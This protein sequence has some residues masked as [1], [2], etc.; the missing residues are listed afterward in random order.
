MKIS[1]RNHRIALI[2]SQTKSNKPS[3]QTGLL[4]TIVRK[5]IDSCRVISLTLTSN[6]ILVIIHR[7]EFKRSLKEHEFTQIKSQHPIRQPTKL[8]NNML[9]K[10]ETKRTMNSHCSKGSDPFEETGAKAQSTQQDSIIGQ[11][12]G[13]H[14][15]LP[16]IRLEQLAA[17][18]VSLHGQVP[19][20]AHLC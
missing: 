10:G 6:Y 19:K 3:L 8:S 2:R 4:L 5:T 16:Q 7:N 1:V 14:A 17:G 12:P 9:V 15:E 20:L 11:L 18:H 13:G